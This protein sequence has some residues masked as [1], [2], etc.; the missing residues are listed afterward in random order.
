M[1]RTFFAALA[2]GAALVVVPASV[3][4]RSDLNAARARLARVDRGVF[5]TAWGTLEFA[6]R[7]SGEP[8]LVSHGIF[9]GRDGGLLSVRDLCP[10]RRVIA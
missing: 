4:Y 10:E 7:G 1:R 3:R 8:L 6:E 9:E 5:P 2:G